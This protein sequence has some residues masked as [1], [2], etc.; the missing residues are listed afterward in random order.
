MEPHHNKST[1]NNLIILAHSLALLLSLFIFSPPALPISS[2]KTIAITEIVV[3]PSL[4][5]AKRGILD[6]L[7]EHGYEMGSNLTVLEATAHNNIATAAM[8]ARKWATLKPDAIIPISTP[9]AQTVIKATSGT[10]IPV[11]FSSVTDPVAAGIVPQLTRNGRI[12]GAIDSPPLD[13]ELLLIQ[14]L[15]PNLKNL[16]VLYNPSEA[17]SVKALALLKKMASPQINL[18]PVSVNSTNDIKSALHSLIGKVD[19]LYVP[20]DNTIFSGLGTVIKITREHKLPLFTSDPDSVKQGALSCVGYTQY[21]VG[22][23]AG[24]QLVKVLAGA[25]DLPVLAPS[26]ISLVVNQTTASLLGIQIG[27]T[28]IGMPLIIE[29]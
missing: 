18:V 9:S 7:K 13:Q 19:A 10:N 14:S 23:T 6:V 21:D 3:H 1:V 22:R 26:K 12:T 28:L 16:G 27:T 29:K 25:S 17:N 15:V 24:E 11:I 20:S 5:E 8:I 2:H 4:L